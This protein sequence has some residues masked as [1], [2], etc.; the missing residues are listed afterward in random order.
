MT[1]RPPPLFFPFFFFFCAP[2]VSTPWPRWLVSVV[3][4]VSVMKVVLRRRSV[5]VRGGFKEG[6][7]DG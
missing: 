7:M 2:N 4:G 3:A 5:G 6:E 1:P